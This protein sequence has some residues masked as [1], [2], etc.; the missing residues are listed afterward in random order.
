M[1]DN[2]N[3]KPILPRLIFRSPSYNSSINRGTPTDSNQ[4]FSIEDADSHKKNRISEAFPPI[5][6][7]SC[8]HCR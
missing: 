2:D 4:A 8:S 5:A 6:D 7:K 1:N 3:N